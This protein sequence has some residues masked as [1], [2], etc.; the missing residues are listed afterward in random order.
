MPEGNTEPGSSEK[1][2]GRKKKC[3][4]VTTPAPLRRS[5]RKRKRSTTRG[6]DPSIHPPSDASKDKRGPKKCAKTNVEPPVVQMDYSKEDVKLLLKFSKQKKKAPNPDENEE[7]TAEEL[8]CEELLKR[9]NCR[10]GEELVAATVIGL[11]LQWKDIDER[12]Q[13]V[14]LYK[15]LLQDYLSKLPEQDRARAA[16]IA[17]SCKRIEA[18]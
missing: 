17:S 13:S 6:F 5:A 18:I 10:K 15:Y 16:S 4:N 3:T 7:K 12:V 11:W 1:A 8:R 9:L 2:T 14:E